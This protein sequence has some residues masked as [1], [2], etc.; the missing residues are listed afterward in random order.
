MLEYN[1]EILSIYTSQSENE[2]SD[3]VKRVTW[4]YQV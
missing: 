3:V 2:L 1:K 4:K